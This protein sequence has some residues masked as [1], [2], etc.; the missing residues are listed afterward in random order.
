M[1][2][3][4]DEML[5][6][7]AKEKVEISSTSEKQKHYCYGRL[8]TLCTC[9]YLLG[10]LLRAFVTISTVGGK[11]ESSEKIEFVFALRLACVSAGHEL[12]CFW[13]GVVPGKKRQPA[14][15]SSGPISQSNR[16]SSGRS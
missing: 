3:G 9:G 16:E 6:L 15:D 8:H 1:K 12:V 4:R 13:T 10:Y 7:S 14:T 11:G 2:L 5:L